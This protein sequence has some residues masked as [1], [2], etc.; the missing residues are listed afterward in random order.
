MMLLELV[1]LDHGADQQQDGSDAAALTLNATPD[2]GVDLEELLELGLQ[3]SL[4]CGGKSFAID[5]NLEQRG[6]ARRPG[7]P[8]GA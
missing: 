8:L 2:Q 1:I 6:E 3:L 5:A 4:L 7:R